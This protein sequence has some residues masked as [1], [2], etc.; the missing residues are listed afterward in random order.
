MP[1]T[2]APRL[3]PAHDLASLRP[4]GWLQL[5]EALAK[6]L[7]IR[8]NWPVRRIA[9]RNGRAR[10]TCGIG[11]TL[12]AQRVVVTASVAVQPSVWC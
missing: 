1:G 2:A 3:M 12:R 8:L 6:G 10:L 5:L 11:A 7:D 4:R 9:V